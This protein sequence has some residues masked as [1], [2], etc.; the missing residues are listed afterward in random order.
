MTNT[1]ATKEW[2][3][4]MI[5]ALHYA[6]CFVYS[7]RGD[8]ILSHLS[9][10]LCEGLKSADPICLPKYVRV[11]HEQF[12]KHAQFQRLFGRD[13]ILVPVPGSSVQASR[14]RVWAAERLAFAL[15]AM[16]LAG[17]VW[18]CLHRIISV[19]RSASSPAGG[20][21][22]VQEHYASFAVETSVAVEA[23]TPDHGPERIVLVDDVITKGRTLLAAATRMR[24]AFPHANL[25][26]FALVRTIR[27][28]DGV[29]T[30]VAP[31]EGLVRWAGGDA[32]RAP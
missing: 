11:V 26:A 29:G 6:S 4:P 17:V 32:R 19:R 3:R 2:S 16:G 7:P 1:I 9:R 5:P 27:L 22:A 28:S 10:R 8:D 15:C 18:R 24:E 23:S 31:C 30:L 20:R 25:Q 12:V 14:Q 21:P 13:V